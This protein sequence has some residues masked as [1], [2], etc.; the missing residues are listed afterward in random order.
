[1]R[2]LLS[3]TVITLLAIADVYADVRPALPKT[4]K[5]GFP[6]RPGAD[7]DQ[8][9][10][11][12]QKALDAA[13]LS[14]GVVTIP[15]GRWLCGP[16]RIHSGTEF[17]LDSGAVL[18]LR[19]DIETYPSQDERYLNFLSIDNKAT[20]IRITGSGTI[21]GQG[22]V[23]WERFTA[24]AITMRRPQMLYGQGVQRLE[25]SGVHFLNPPN[26]HISLK[27]CSDVH[28]KGITIEAPEKSRNTDGINIS[29]RN[30]LIED[31]EI[32]TGDDNIAINFGGRN[33]STD[34]PECENIEIRN[35]RFGHGHGLS[36]GSYTS[37]HLRGL[38]VHDCS[39]DGT[40]AALRIKSA[41]GRGGLV[42]NLRYRNITISGS[43]WPVFISAYYPKEPKEP[44]TAP[45]AVTAT[46]PVYKRLR[47]ENIVIDNSEVALRLHGLPETAIEDLV[48]E[49]CSFSARTGMQISDVKGLHF[50]NCKLQVR[51]GKRISSVNAQLEGLS[52]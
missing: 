2:R 10:A 1:M 37:G 16:L 44:E 25:I 48:F 31:C 24:K 39:F 8:N 42:E 40:T 21:D 29:A 32:A 5:Q 33:F 27:D 38:D 13:G 12:I 3:F 41:R 20:D 51:E 52:N 45:E 15:A 18:V 23:W 11:T 26:T 7:A 49:N 22:S 36:I 19:D 43:K 6:V 30:C 35:C 9:T 28:I 14:G 34:A 47:F 46:T 4:G 50:K 17:R